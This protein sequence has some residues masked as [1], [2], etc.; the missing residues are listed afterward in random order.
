VTLTGEGVWFIEQEQSAW[1][2]ARLA[3]P[4]QVN[5]VVPKKSDHDEAE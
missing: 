4:E 3:L 1:F 2:F 5:D